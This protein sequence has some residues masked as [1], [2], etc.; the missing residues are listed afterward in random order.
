MRSMSKP[1]TSYSLIQGGS[2]YI[3][4]G[5]DVVHITFTEIEEATQDFSTKIGKGS[6][7]NVYYGKLKDGK[8]VAVK[9]LA[10]AS[11]HG[12]KQFENE[13][14]SFASILMGVGI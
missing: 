1:S 7:G 3:D 10:D 4:D 14:F 6:F 11:Y 13:V 12:T 8:E 9:I 2:V 5:L